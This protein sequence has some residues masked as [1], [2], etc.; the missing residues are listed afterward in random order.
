MPAAIQQID[1]RVRETRHLGFVLAE[2]VHGTGEIIEEL[3]AIELEMIDRQAEVET[4]HLQE[5]NQP[6]CQFDIA[7]ADAL[8]LAQG[9]EEGFVSRSIELSGD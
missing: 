1:D 6:M 7:V 9:H 2:A 8:G 4:I 3:R 5:V